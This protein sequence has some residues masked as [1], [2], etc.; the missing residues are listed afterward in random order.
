MQNRES[1][2]SQADE[3][4]S[5]RR[6]WQSPRLSVLGSLTSLTESGS[7]TMGESALGWC[8]IVDPSING[9]C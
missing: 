4:T 1:E 8:L 2:I 9:M 5:Q 3:A 6:S 7:M